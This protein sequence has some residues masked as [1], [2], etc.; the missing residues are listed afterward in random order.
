MISPHEVHR[1][2]RRPAFETH[3]I[4]TTL[5]LLSRRS[6]RSYVATIN[7]RPFPGLSAH[8]HPT[9]TL[10]DESMPLGR[11]EKLLTDDIDAAPDLHW[12]VVITAR[13]RGEAAGRMPN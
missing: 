5:A 2:S 4:N 13:G 11:F 8:I 1:P 3:V 9:I 10:N 7:R 6:L 12:D